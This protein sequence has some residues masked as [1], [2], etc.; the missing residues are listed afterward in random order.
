MANTYSQLYYHMVWSVKNRHSLLTKDIKEDI[1]RYITGIVT[2]QGQKLMAIN[3]HVDHIHM[4]I[5]CRTSVQPDALMKEVKEHSTRFINTNN[6]TR[7][8]FYWQGGYGAFSVSKRN[9]DMIIDY[10]TNQEEHHRK[11]TF[12]EEYIELLNENGVDFDARYIF[13]DPSAVA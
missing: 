7:Q 9:S 8:K 5:S 1:H 4:L 12:R 3:S 13:Y 10:I 6:L 11:K 2:N